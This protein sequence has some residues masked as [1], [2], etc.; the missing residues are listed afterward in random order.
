MQITRASWFLWP[1]LVAAL[2]GQTVTNQ[3][4]SVSLQECIEMA[5]LH[6]RDI[7]I[8]RFNPVI[9]RLTLEGSYSYYEPRLTMGSQG[10][11]IGHSHSR[12]F[13]GYD[14][15]TGLPTPGTS[16]ETYM[17]NANFSGALPS[18]MTYSLG[19][20]YNNNFGTSGGREFDNFRTALSISINQPLLKNF[21]TDLGRTTIQV[22]KK[23]LKITE[24]G[25]DYVVMN[26]VAEVQQAY[27]ELIYARGN[28][29]VQEKVL[30]AKQR[31][32]NETKRK[33]E[34]GTLPQLEEKLA[35]S[36]VAR[37]QSDLISARNSVALAEN[38]LKGLLGDDFLSSVG[39]AVVPSD[40]MIVV[41]EA[42]NVAESW[43]RGLAKRPDVMQMKLD[44]AK[45]DLDLKYRRNQ[46][47][48]ALD[49]FASY[50]LSGRSPTSGT[51][52][53]ATETLGQI[54]G[55]ENPSDTIGVIF[56]VP[57]TRTAERSNY[58][59]SKET[60][61]QTILKLKRLEEQVLRQ[62]DDAIK[63]TRTALERVTATREATVYA[64][65]ALEAETKKLEAGKS[66]PY[67][68]L[69]LQSD[70]GTTASAEIR[71]KADYNQALSKLL[72]YEGTILERCKLA[73]EVK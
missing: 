15:I 45:A 13:G 48:P 26:V 61:A 18:G 9:S 59:A 66:T 33:V 57:L 63:T 44:I 11:P 42:V 23:N 52:G 29:T 22:N 32:Y 31:F 49:L 68:V 69:Q 54:R 24:L 55:S 2:H 14:P 56:S 25:V 50:G 38:A 30:E 67:V 3:S 4:R 28:V 17:A 65:A 37:V 71:A 16:Q 41:P 46:L 10:A 70:L 20:S 62:I 35:Q 36:Q 72:F 8:E 64:Q 43:Q 19:S 5:L 34:I 12:S 39:I 27:Y 1:L 60:R 6:N 58:K 40:A 73:V 21:W 47:F 53:S 51:I 7:Q